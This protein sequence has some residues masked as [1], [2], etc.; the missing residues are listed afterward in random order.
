MHV[1]AWDGSNGTLSKNGFYGQDTEAGTLEMAHQS[2]FGFETMNVTVQVRKQYST[3]VENR[4]KHRIN[5]HPIINFPM[6][7][8]VSEVNE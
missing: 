2:P 7:E 6:S 8:G 3:M 1:K 5:S 4:K